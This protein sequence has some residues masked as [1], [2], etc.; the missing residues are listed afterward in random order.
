MPR[1]ASL[2]MAFVLAGCGTAGAIRESEGYA[3]EGQYAESVEVLREQLR[4]N[5]DDIGLRNAYYRR[6]ETLVRDAVR[7]ADAAL[8]RGDDDAA[9]A[10]LRKV[11]AYDPANLG[12]QQEIHRI[13]VIRRLR[14]QLDE[15]RELQR[16]D[17]QAAL[18]RVQQVLDQ[19]PN[20]RE[21]QALRESLM[22]RLASVDA[23][24]PKLSAALRKPVTLNFREQSLTAIFELIARIAGISIVLD[25][26]INPNARASISATTTT[27]EDAINLLLATANLQKQYL[28]ADT[29]LIY[30]SRPDKERD[31]RSL[32]VRTFFL[33]H[34][35][36][37]QAVAQIK[38]LFRPKEILVDDRLNGVVVRDSVET[39]QA[40]ERLIQALDLPQSEVTLDVQVLEVARNDL[41]NLGINYP[42]KITGTLSEAVN[43]GGAGVAV[44]ALRNINADNILLDAGSPQVT[45]NLLQRSGNTQTLAN[46]KIRVRNREKATISIGERVP[47]VTTTNANGVVTE[48]VQ[49]QDVGL[50]LDVEP[51]ISL[52][53]EISIRLAMDVSNIISETVTR[54]GLITYV[55]GT[56]SA[57]TTL[58]ARN[59]E[60]QVLAGLIRRADIKTGE[61]LPGLSRI[62]VL[63]R[64]FGTR[65][66]KQEQTEIVLLITPHIERSLDLPAFQ[67]STFAS[68]T[69]ARPG[70]QPLALVGSEG[71]RVSVTPDPA[72]AGTSGALPP[73]AMPLAAPQVVQAPVEHVA[74]PAA[75]AAAAASAV[76]AAPPPSMTA[77]PPGRLGEP[78]AAPR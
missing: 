60:T 39:L 19:L 27:A 36:P 25:K 41:L 2:L 56:R 57:K 58:T 22:Q 47:V 6:V 48:S 18:R 33:S 38:Q 45:L 63:D 15:A 9:I 1:A 28:N 55:L 40:I 21:A 46:P 62:P 68:G 11:L 72:G 35:D 7:E 71:V 54:T 50:K 69:E 67:V 29:I 64:I 13:Q 17:P 12:A 3:N 20:L 43:P 70:I 26:D 61:G 77:P 34:S 14:P 52:S 49:Y 74:P 66:D 73:P 10:A 75:P 16:S 5:P 65:Q 53:N 24:S 4:R 51:N 30:P 42:G 31:Y 23:L 59:N 44:S 32:A 37:R 78:P 76:P 8:E